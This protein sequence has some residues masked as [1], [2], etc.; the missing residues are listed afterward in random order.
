[1]WFALWFIEDN[2]VK[3]FLS[4]MKYL[5]DPK[6]HRRECRNVSLTFLERVKGSFHKIKYYTANT[7]Q[8]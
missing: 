2:E 6:N 1:M 4:S 7:C 3:I 8:N 5:K